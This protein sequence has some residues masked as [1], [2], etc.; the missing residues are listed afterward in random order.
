MILRFGLLCQVAGS[1]NL[2]SC[3]DFK[4]E[5][6]AKGEHTVNWQLENKQRKRQREREREKER[7]RER[8]E[9]EREREN[10]REKKKLVRT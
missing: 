9:R 6:S 2:C 7:E 1:R 4:L 5:Q 3:M 10:E 8:R